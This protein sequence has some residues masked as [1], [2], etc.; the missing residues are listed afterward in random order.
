MKI[1]DR[2]LTVARVREVLDYDTVEGSLTW[3]I[4]LSKN[5]PVGSRAG[6]VTNGNHYVKL[7][8]V[9]YTTQ[10]LAWFHYHGEWPKGRV[11]F[12]NKVKGDIRLTNLVQM[13]PGLPDVDPSTYGKAHRAA[14]PLQYRDKELRKNFGIGLE[15]YQAMFVAHG[16]VCAICKQPETAAR[17][18]KDLWLSVDH[19]HT[20]GKLRGLLCSNCNRGI[21]CFGDDQVKLGNAISYLACHAEP[22]PENVLPFKKED[23]A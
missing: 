13:N 5:V 18:G 3:K 17:G 20:T 14:Y 4:R 6:R 9:S 2:K 21:G 10:R 22:M 1:Q 11:T 8:G 16:G 12:K 15:E 19:N 7:D 23:A